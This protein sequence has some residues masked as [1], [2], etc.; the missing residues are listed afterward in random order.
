MRIPL[1]R[2]QPTPGMLL[3]E[4]R[5]YIVHC[6]SILGPVDSSFRA[7]SGRLKLT[8]RRLSLD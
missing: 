4:Y 5:L 6:Q 3:L 1:S 7:L 8:V 2:Q